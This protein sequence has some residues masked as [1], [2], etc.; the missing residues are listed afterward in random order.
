MILII[1]FAITSMVAYAEGTEKVPL[2]EPG[3]N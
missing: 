3:L 1:A 2:K